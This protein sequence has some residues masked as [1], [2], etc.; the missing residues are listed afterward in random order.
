MFVF[1]LDGERNIHRRAIV[2]SGDPVLDISFAIS[3]FSVLQLQRSQRRRHA[4]RLENHAWLERQ[5]GAQIGSR[6]RLIARKLQTIDTEQGSFPH[7]DHNSPGPAR[8]IEHLLRRFHFGGQITA[9]LV[10]TRDGVN[11]A[12]R[13]PVHRQSQLPF[14]NQFSDLAGPLAFS[15]LHHDLHVPIVYPRCQI[16]ADYFAVSFDRRVRTRLCAQK[17]SWA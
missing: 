11:G 13:V 4:G 14:V 16:E 3:E 5:P 10:E 9:L 7:R 12:P 2:A 8:G 6:Q 15:T 1:L 17:S